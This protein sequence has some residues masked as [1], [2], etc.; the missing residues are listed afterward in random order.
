[1]SGREL[2][3]WSWGWLHP[4]G[5]TPPE[6]VLVHRCG[7]RFEGVPD[8][9]PPLPAFARY[10]EL[11]ATGLPRDSAPDVRA[12]WGEWVRLSFAGTGWDR[13]RAIPK[14]IAGHHLG[15]AATPAEARALAKLT[16]SRERHG[17]TDAEALDALG[18]QRQG[19]L[20]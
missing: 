4:S 20:L 10:G 18:Q 7:W 11:M 12:E 9:R 16:R 19:V 3:D 2:P 13:G 15:R 1:M 14:M 6:L 8:G 5:P 17:C